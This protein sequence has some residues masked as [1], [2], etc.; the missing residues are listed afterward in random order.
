M[1]FEC[2]GTWR[3]TSTRSILI[4]VRDSKI[5]A[6]ADA[7]GFSVVLRF[8][9]RL[10]GRLARLGRVLKFCSSPARRSLQ[11]P[12]SAVALLGRMERWLSP[13]F[14]SVFPVASVRDSLCLSLLSTDSQDFQDWFTCSLLRAP[15]SLLH[16]SC[17]FASVADLPET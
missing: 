10:S 4:R 3:I 7:L 6:V 17:S 2:S 14:G 12:S 16:Y 15:C 9:R 13:C 5:P 1:T 11:R 8:S